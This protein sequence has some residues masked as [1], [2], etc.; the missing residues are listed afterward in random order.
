MNRVCLLVDHPLRDLD[1]L[2][3]VAGHLAAA[4]T[5]VFLVPMYQKHEVWLLRP[6]LVLVN[7][8]RHAHASFLKTCLAGGIQVAVL[9]T[10]GGVRDFSGFSAEVEPY[11][12][13]IS[14][15][16]VW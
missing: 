5:E 1:G 8:L 9:D 10:E 12:P 11:L 6:D 14:L 4:G 2:L 7:Y 13:G 15:Y 16:C 3:L